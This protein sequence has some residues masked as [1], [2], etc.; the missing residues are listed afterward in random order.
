MTSNIQT[1]NIQTSIAPYL[2]EL[3]LYDTIKHHAMLT[4]VREYSSKPGSTI[5]PIEHFDEPLMTLEDITI[6]ILSNQSRRIEN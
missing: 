3:E 5:K 2:K 4:V 6:E 1:S